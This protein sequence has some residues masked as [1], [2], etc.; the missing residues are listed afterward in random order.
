M[1]CLLCLDKIITLPLI[2]LK[3]AWKA[4]RN[5]FFSIYNFKSEFFF[6]LRMFWYSASYVKIKS[7]YGW[8]DHNTVI[9][10][11]SNHCLNKVV[12]LIQS[13]CSCISSLHTYCSLYIQFTNWY[14]THTSK[15][16]IHVCILNDLCK[17]SKLYKITRNW[18]RYK[19][20]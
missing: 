9:Q 10:T 5:T 6:I 13:T 18:H 11:M 12:K 2:S 15:L 8:K 19:T 3:Y 20:M 17:F 7:Y 14:I 4:I 1:K 16:T